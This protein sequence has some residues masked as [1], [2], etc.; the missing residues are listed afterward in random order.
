MTQL[1]KQFTDRQVKELFEHFRDM[2][3]K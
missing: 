3:V 1:Q 2:S